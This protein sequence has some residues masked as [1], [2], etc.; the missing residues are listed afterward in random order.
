MITQLKFVG[1]PT[2]DQDRAL[3]FYTAQLGFEIS[4][5]QNFDDRTAHREFT[6]ARRAVYSAGTRR[7]DRH[8]LQRLVR[9]R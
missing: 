7:A 3:A 2:R 8:V 9:L 5:D 4:T 6:D 1:I